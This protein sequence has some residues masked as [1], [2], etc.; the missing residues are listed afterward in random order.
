MTTGRSTARAAKWSFI[1]TVGAK[2]ITLGGLTVLA[3][4]LDPREFGLL[5]FAM[6]YIV[7]VETIGDLG[8]GTALIYWPDR[9]EDAAQVTFLIN[10]AA[11]MGWCIVTLLLAP[12]IADFFNA[13]EGTNIVRALAIGFIIKYLG[14]TH[15]ALT[16]K[17]LRFQARALPELALSL[18]KAG[19]SI[20]LAWKGF[21]AWSLVAG[22]LAGLTASTAFFWTITSWRPRWRFPR[23]LFKPMLAY[24]RGIISVNILEAVLMQT[25]LA[26]VGRS[27]GVTALGL[28]QLAGKLPE[29]TV[30]VIVR[31]A[32]RVLLPA[33]SRV[34]ASGENPKHAYLAAA[35]YI[36][37]VTLPLSAGL[38]ILS[39]PL[40][41]VFF[42][43]DWI[44]AAPILTALAI[45]A[46]IRTLGV[47][48]G[49]VLKATGRVGTLA[50]I[51]ILRAVLVV[52]VVIIAAQK[53]AVT[54]ATSLALVDG[55]AVTVAFLIT[56]RVIGVSPRE[57]GRAYA[58]SLA[59]VTAMSVA[60]LSWR[61]WGVDLPAAYE[62]AISVTIGATTYLLALAILAPQ[63]LAEARRM[64]AFGH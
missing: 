28:Y 20:L 64:F 61:T 12:F 6:A 39:E 33:F 52:V 23:D 54:V 17:D 14:N 3:R 51:Q 56:A 45:L 44:A 58:P 19:V 46:G 7:Y 21:G 18:V 30:T 53:S 22:H 36:A 9:R 49:D 57:I 24:G 13:P 48:S 40:V 29:A 41:L 47:Q 35:R 59:A 60:V 32:G 11:G 50:R 26:A 5:A 37:A 27:L 16:R 1:A 4:L 38:A 8:T 42:G 55:I 2:L 62:V 43:A 10:L 31:I 25:D 63:M 15:D 34:A